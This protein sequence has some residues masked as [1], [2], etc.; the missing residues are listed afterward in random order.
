MRASTAN[1]IADMRAARLLAPFALLTA[2][3]LAGCFEYTG[4]PWVRGTQAE[5]LEGER[6]RDPATIEQLRDRQMRVQS[7]R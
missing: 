2:P 3:L 1:G 4:D 6:A 7:D 5:Q